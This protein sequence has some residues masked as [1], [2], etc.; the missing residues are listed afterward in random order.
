MGSIHASRLLFCALSVGLIACSSDD[1]P[2]TC[3]ATGDVVV[4]VTV[5]QD[6]WADVASVTGTGACVYDSTAR[7]P[8]GVYLFSITGVGL[9]HVRMSFHLAAD[10]ES[11]I[12]VTQ[13]TGACCMGLMPEHAT[14]RVPELADASTRQ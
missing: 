11:D 3:P 5:P 6:R 1:C 9:C 7:T 2:H 12:E 8:A 13:S 14:V 4:T 10:F